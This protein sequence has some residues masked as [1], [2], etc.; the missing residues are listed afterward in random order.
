MSHRQAVLGLHSQNNKY[1]D[2]YDNDNNVDDNVDDNDNDNDDDDDND[3]N[4]SFHSQVQLV[5]GLK[6][7][8]KQF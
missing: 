2:E 8:I 6:L 7:D 5:C 4:K 1:K 3:N